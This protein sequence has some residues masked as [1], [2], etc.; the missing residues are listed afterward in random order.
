ML[1]WKVVYLSVHRVGWSI[2]RGVCLLG[3]VGVDC[4]VWFMNGGMC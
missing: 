4:G 1:L 2:R 3:G